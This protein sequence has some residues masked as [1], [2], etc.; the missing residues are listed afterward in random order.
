VGLRHPQI[1]QITQI[2]KAEG[3][4]AVGSRQS[5]VGR[6]QDADIFHF[7]FEISHLSFQKIQES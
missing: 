7:P 2:N 1:T 5:A 4:K 6:E 3:R